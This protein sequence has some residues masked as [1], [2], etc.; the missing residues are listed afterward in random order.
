VCFRN[1]RYD[2]YS[3]IENW[4]LDNQ[5][6]SDGSG[7]EDYDYGARMLDPQLGV[8]HN[9]DPL[10]DKSRRWSPYNYGADNPIRFIDPDGMNILDGIGAVQGQSGKQEMSDDDLVNVVVTQDGDG[11][12]Y[13]SVE[14]A[15]SGNS[16]FFV[17]VGPN[18][19]DKSG[20]TQSNP[21]QENR[22]KFADLQKNYLGDGFSAKDVYD[23]I[24]GKVA[25]NYHADQESNSCTLRLSRGLNYSGFPITNID[26]NILYGTGSDGLKY[27][28]R[29]TDM[30]KQ[31][32]S[33]FGTPDIVRSPSDPDF[34][35]AFNGKQGIIAFQV[36]GWGDA[37][38]HVTIWNGSSCG[39]HCYFDGG[40]VSQPSVQTVKVMLWVLK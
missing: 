36:S 26:K 25:E 17:G 13:T 1:R 40:G 22:P 21:N 34:K 38:G 30:I 18:T 5:E 9:L 15:T 3:F 7:I 12:T 33:A 16:T 23:K 35:S 39:F 11:N 32:N 31:L 4:R 27:I 10:A 37:T 6:F 2:P 8:W 29:V 24:G 14:D 19:G 28:Y 20:E